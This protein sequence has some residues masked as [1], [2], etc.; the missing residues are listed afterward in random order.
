MYEVERHQ[1]QHPSVDLL[2]ALWGKAYVSRALPPQPGATT[3]FCGI[4]SIVY[5]HIFNQRFLMP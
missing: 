4:N 2:P 1:D 3:G 5:G